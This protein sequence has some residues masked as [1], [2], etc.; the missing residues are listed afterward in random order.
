MSAPVVYEHVAAGAALQGQL[1]AGKKFFVTQRCPMRNYFLDLVRNN[2]GEIVNL[3]KQA[4]HLI[5]DH[6]K[7]KFCPP[8][9]ISYTFIEKSVKNAQLEDPED[10]LAA[11]AARP[12]REVGSSRPA[13]V[14][15]AAY[16]ADED[17]ILYKWVQDHVTQGGSASGNE[18]YKQLEE[19]HPQHSWQ[20]WR[21]H[22]IKQ[23]RDRPL[24]AFV[25]P[26]N[27]PPSPPSDQSA[28]RMPPNVPQSREQEQRARSPAT[29][30]NSN[31]VAAPSTAGNEGVERLQAD[32]DVDKFDELFGV[33]DW[34]YLYANVPHI[35]SVSFMDYQEGWT[36]WAEGETQTREEWREFF[37]TRVLPQWQKDP[38]SKRGEITK[39]VEGRNQQQTKKTK[40][41]EVVEVQA[42]SAGEGTPLVQEKTE[43]ATEDV[44]E[45]GPSTPRVD[46]DIELPDRQSKSSSIDDYAHR[47][48]QTRKG[49]Q[50][51]TAYEWFAREQRG[52]IS[53]QHSTFDQT[54]VDKVL[55]GKWRALSE[56]EKQP[57][58]TIEIAD[59]TRHES[60]V[61]SS[62]QIGSSTTAMQ[63]TPEVIAK[64]YADA[65][66]R[67]LGEVGGSE[68]EVNDLAPTSK[69]RRNRSRTPIPGEDSAPPPPPAVENQRNIV[70]IS[71]AESSSAES[72][73]S[74]D[75]NDEE[76][77]T[78][79]QVDNPTIEE[80]NHGKNQ[81]D[82]I[83]ESDEP[84]DVVSEQSPENIEMPCSDDL[85]SNTP[86][87]RAHRHMKTSFD[88][89]AILQSQSHGLS[90]SAPRPQD[91]LQ[92]IKVSDKDR[93]RSHSIEA[94][95]PA[96]KQESIAST[97]QSM[98][99]FRRS[100]DNAEDDTSAP[101]PPGLQPLPRPKDESQDSVIPPSTPSST[102]SEDVDPP[103][104]ADEIEDF[105]NEQ[106]EHGFSNKEISAALRSTR[107]RPE[108][109][110][111]VLD[112]WA[113]GKHL[114][115][116]RGIWSKE[117]DAAVESG[118]GLAL[119]QLEQKHSLDGWGGITERM[120]F[121]DQCRKR[122]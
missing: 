26:Q 46:P 43:T 27:A 7:P 18:I 39:R 74:A 57:Y 93:S 62:P 111:E 5:A 10:H 122:S 8:G 51:M 94:S 104:E 95:S 16:T 36:R 66:K 30:H 9:S 33:L 103:L 17:R 88:T 65:K 3:E 63:R 34:E 38:Q 89:Q 28:E 90:P 44:E 99:E 112:A 110:I 96:H 14:G 32:K 15:R 69:R 75:Y 45:A 98:H 116:K 120:R 84:E 58:L 56:Q 119:A 42:A 24:S 52:S 35:T 115:N 82:E 21:D 83:D 64:A 4:D 107:C 1:F 60:E 59:R 108:L 85:P 86:A 40:G 22:Y 114:P 70:E 73:S 92:P 118:D 106:Q 117:D 105:Y 54:Q 97:P 31:N 49:K 121:L 77:E 2:G 109:A 101:Q 12:T 23:L 20:S 87:P 80:I 11:P 48:Q 78:Q 37:E 72:S 25:P 113:D 76:P 55:L 68:G 53:E 67:I 79:R 50:P 71:S 81:R 100:L 91:F 13:K 61:A 41:S 19:K 6:F 29:N 102:G 47:L